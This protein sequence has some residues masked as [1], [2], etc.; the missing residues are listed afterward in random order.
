MITYRG[1]P[2]RIWPVFVKQLHLRF[3]KH[4]FFIILHITTIFFTLWLARA[5][6]TSNE[7]LFGSKV[8]KKNV[9]WLKGRTLNDEI[10]LKTQVG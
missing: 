3:K 10:I 9:E 6:S 4:L 1:Q 5:P 8:E 2:N 7:N